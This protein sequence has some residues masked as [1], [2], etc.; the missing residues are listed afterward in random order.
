MTTDYLGVS[1]DSANA[2]IFLG[3]SS[4]YGDATIGMYGSLAEKKKVSETLAVIR[5]ATGGSVAASRP[6]RDPD[7]GPYRPNKPFNLL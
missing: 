7:A 3:D 2:K 5:A 6:E 4:G 1:G